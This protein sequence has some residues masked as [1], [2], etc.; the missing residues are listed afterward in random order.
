[1][2]HHRV[3]FE[4]GGQ[5]DQVCAALPPAASNEVSYDELLDSVGL[6]M[7]RYWPL[8]PSTCADAAKEIDV[9]NTGEGEH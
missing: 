2:K 7:A 9:T 4:R 8:N 1:M 5:A 3:S 6:P